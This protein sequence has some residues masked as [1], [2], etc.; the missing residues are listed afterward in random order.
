LLR[1]R[2]NFNIVWRALLRLD[3]DFYESTQAE[4]EQLYPR[5]FAP[6]AGAQVRTL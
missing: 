5:E 6:P 1:R 3:T 2:S 4:I